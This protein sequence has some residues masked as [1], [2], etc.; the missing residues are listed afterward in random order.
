MDEARAFGESFL[1]AGLM[2][3]YSGDR[4]SYPTD[5]LAG[6]LDD[7]IALVERD[8]GLVNRYGLRRFPP[9]LEKQIVE[10]PENNDGARFREFLRQSREAVSKGREL[11]PIPNDVKGIMKTMVDERLGKVVRSSRGEH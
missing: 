11:P 3:V 5:K 6:V 2:T 9:E 10:L 1:L 4:A 7:G 8:L